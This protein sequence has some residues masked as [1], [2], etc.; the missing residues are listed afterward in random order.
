M[1][2]TFAGAPG[3]FP[4]EGERLLLI[5]QREFQDHFLADGKFGTGFDEDAPDADIQYIALKGAI[6]NPIIGIYQAW[7]ARM[8]PHRGIGFLDAHRFDG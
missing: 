6:L 3:N 4:A 5:V 8:F 1:A 2:K 7:F